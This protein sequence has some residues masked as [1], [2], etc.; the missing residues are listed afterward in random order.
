MGPSVKVGFGMDT[1]PL[2]EYT[3][4]RLVDARNYLV[5]GPLEELEWSRIY[6]LVCWAQRGPV[7]RNEMGRAIDREMAYKEAERSI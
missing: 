1:R 3:L 2:R 4:E 5:P 7:T 6:G